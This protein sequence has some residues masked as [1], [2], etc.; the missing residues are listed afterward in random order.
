MAAFRFSRR[1]EDDLLHIGD[2][3]LHTWGKA[4]TARY[5][6]ELEVCCQRL[7][8]NPAFGRSCPSVQPGLRRFEHGEHVMFYR[9]ASAG[10]FISRI[11]HRR[12]LPDI[13]IF[14]D[15]DNDL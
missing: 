11:L 13:H 9:Q 10:I 15:R 4:Q 3:T 12:M 1:A 7:A 14:E 2:Y 5:L 6:G 8:D